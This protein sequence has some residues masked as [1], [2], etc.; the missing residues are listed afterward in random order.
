MASDAALTP[1]LGA[2][3]LL[4]LVDRLL[5][6]PDVASLGTLALSAVAHATGR[7]RLGLYVWGDDPSRTRRVAS[8][9]VSAQ[10]LRHYERR[11][12][13][14]DPVVDAAVRRRTA[15]R[16]R[17][18]MPLSQWRTTEHYR[19]VAVMHRFAEVVIAPIAVDG[20]VTATLHVGDS[21]G[22]PPIS[23][24]EV[25]VVRA[26]AEAVGVALAQRRRTEV[27]AP[28]LAVLS[29]REREV[30][31]L[32]ADDRSDAEIAA[33]LRIS[34]HT[35]GQHLKSVYRKLGVRSRVGLTRRVLLTDGECH[36]RGM[37]AVAF[38]A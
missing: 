21:D 19:R 4:R 35:V 17:D 36:E 6:T 7:P 29:P 5:R 20:R 2:V 14:A 22:A 28:A 26:I 9:N 11:G 12:I 1:G 38:D 30:A 13:L 3:G 34:P 24:R 10:F 32:V 16:H 8:T 23:S 31:V 27:L 37:S 18:V 33:L 25:E 15:T